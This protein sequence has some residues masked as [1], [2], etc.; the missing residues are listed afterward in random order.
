MHKLVELILRLRHF[1]YDVGIKKSHSFTTPKTIVIGNLNLGGTGKSPHTRF[2]A[3]F[4]LSKKYTVAILSRGYKRKT[5]GFL[6]VTLNKS[7][8]EVGDEPYM[9]KA[10]FKNM[11]QVFVGENRVQ[12][13]QNIAKNHPEIQ[14]VLLDDAFQHRKLIGGFQVLLTPAKKTFLA[15]RLFPIGNLRDIASRANSADA[16]VATNFKTEYQAN[17]KNLQLA[18][19]QKLVLC[20]WL[21]YGSTQGMNTNFNSKPLKNY[22][23]AV[24]TGIANASEFLTEL[25]RE[26]EIM[27][28]FE[29]NDHHAFSTSEIAQIIEFAKN[30]DSNER[31][32][33]ITTEK[34]WFRLLYFNEFKIFAGSNNVGYLP[35]E[36]TMFDEHSNLLQKNILHYVESN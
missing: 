8:E 10:Y 6:E 13:I 31:F 16:I 20:S 36:V 24:V 2:L 5:K 11:L 3:E 19:P 23:L 26:N 27:K 35:I 28:H 30:Q 12:A 1:L 21:N 14:V 22:Q 18:Y 25:N 33:L 34:D 4:L 29:F 9:Q 15:D 32:A 7:V 17:F